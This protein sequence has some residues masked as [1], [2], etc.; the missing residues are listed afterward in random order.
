MI[1]AH[2]HQDSF[3][4]WL[5]ELQR[6]CGQFESCP[7]PDDMPFHGSVGTRLAG[8][9]EVA[10][11]TTNAQ[12]IVRERPCS[13]R[14][15]DRY[16]FLIVQRQG[17]ARLIQQGRTID[18]L[19]GEMALL[20]SARDCEILPQGF[21]EHSSF[22]LPRDA[23]I[24]RFADRRVPFGKLNTGNASGQILQL[25]V[26]RVVSRQLS[27]PLTEEDGIGL[28]DSLLSLLAPTCRDDADAVTE[29]PAEGEEL[30]RCAQQLIEQ[31]LQDE[32][33]TPSFLAEQLHISVRRLYRLF[34]H[35]GD[36]VCRY[37]QRQRLARCA[38]ALSDPSRA[39][40][41]ITEIAYHWG[42]TDSAHFSRAFK[43]SHGMSPR[44][45]RR[46]H[47]LH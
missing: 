42:F 28:R 39:R 30:Y 36:S 31:R 43:K 6:T 16:C 11:I 40:H 23:V 45:Y 37:V 5:A 17:R 47:S 1:S 38:E 24:E 20:D 22:H 14:E 34:E 3:S 21:I 44:D 32:R 7:L 27:E 2:P 10:E 19:P 12:R 29:A 35:H 9:L 8:S 13:D 33:L 26:N 18:M 4:A 15:E 41:S 25:I 46:H